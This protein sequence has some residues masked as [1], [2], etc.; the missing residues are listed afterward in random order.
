MLKYNNINFI[1]I[2]LINYKSFNLP[3]SKIIKYYN[4]YTFLI[5]YII[6]RFTGHFYNLIIFLYFTLNIP[7]SNIFLYN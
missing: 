2:L 7:S 5:Y 4:H 1:Y 6:I 3:C